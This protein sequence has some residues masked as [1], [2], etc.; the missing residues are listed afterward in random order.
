MIITLNT[1]KEKLIEKKRKKNYRDF[2]FRFAA[3][4]SN[5]LIACARLF[6]DSAI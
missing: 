4:A 5:L 1:K 2:E 3:C 6:I